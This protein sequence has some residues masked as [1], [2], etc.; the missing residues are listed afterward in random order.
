MIS[1]LNTLGRED[2]ISGCSRRLEMKRR[3]KKNGEGGRDWCSHHRRRHRLRGLRLPPSPPPP[4]AATAG[5]RRSRCYRCH[6]WAQ[7]PPVTAKRWSTHKKK[8]L[9]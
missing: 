2:W 9:K 8:R 3:T 6:L 5:S 4:G 1:V 7:P